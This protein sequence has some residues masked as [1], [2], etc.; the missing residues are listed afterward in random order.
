MRSSDGSSQAGCCGVA[1]TGAL[2]SKFSILIYGLDTF[3]MNCVCPAGQ[4]RP[5]G[6]GKLL[7]T[8]YYLGWRDIREKRRPRF[9]KA[10]TSAACCEFTTQSK[11][12]SSHAAHLLR[13]RE[14][15][16]CRQ[17]GTTLRLLELSTFLVQG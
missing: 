12:M 11:P 1:L 2:V 5:G 4:M 9:W 3:R 10:S 15:F 6:D 7:L 8:P 14:R 13:Y 17:L 16:R